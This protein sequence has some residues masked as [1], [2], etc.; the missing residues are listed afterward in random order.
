VAPHG[1]HARVG[2]A[3]HH[4]THGAAQKPPQ[5]AGAGTWGLLHSQEQAPT[6]LA[7]EEQAGD[8]WCFP[9]P[10]L[11]PQKELGP[12]AAMHIQIIIPVP[13]A[14]CPSCG[15][16]AEGNLAAGSGS[17]SPLKHHPH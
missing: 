12:G 10:C 8:A 14:G 15:A 7:P 2:S 4:I 6:E 5:G 13:L 17:A 3:L 16:A 1:G 9:S 11:A